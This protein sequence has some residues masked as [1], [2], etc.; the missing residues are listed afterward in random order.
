MDVK[1]QTAAGW[2]MLLCVLVPWSP[3]DAQT[4]APTPAPTSETKPAGQELSPTRLVLPTANDNLYRGNGEKYY[5]YVH[6]NFEGTDSRAWTA[7]K[8]GFVRN[9][10]RTE[11]GVIGTRFHE[12]IDVK[13]LKRDSSNNPLDEILAISGGIVVYV[14]FSSA[15]SNYGKYVVVEHLWKTGSMFSLYAHLSKV[16]VKAGQQIKQGE[17]IGIMGYTGR[18]INRERSHLHLELNVL[19]STKFSAWHEKHFGTQNIHGIHNGI[20]LA[21]L[22]VS[23]LY[24]AQLRNK[25]LTVPQFLRS[26]P[27]HYKVTIPRAGKLDLVERNPWLARGDHSKPSPSWEVS[28]TASG[29]P[30]SVVPSARAVTAPRVSSIRKCKSKHEYH[31]KG[32]VSG[33]GYRASLS[34]LGVRYLELISE[35]TDSNTTP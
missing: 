3:L 31:T 13:P 25:N 22:D 27:A 21:G 33:T 29:F 17:V 15:K 7:G 18:G 9:M 14:N 24:L 5:M 19:L 4:D 32:F 35:V 28:F 12:G 34:K 6:R 2:L 1:K 8:Y 16:H 30:L 26:V 11:D 10:R 23:K 20:N